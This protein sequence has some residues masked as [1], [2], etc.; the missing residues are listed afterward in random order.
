MSQPSQ[1]S[2]TFSGTDGLT[3]FQL[4]KISMATNPRFYGNLLWTHIKQRDDMR[5]VFDDM[6]TQHPNG[7]VSTKRCIK[8]MA[9]GDVLVCWN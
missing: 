1:V 5:F 3:T 2:T 9:G 8:V 7:L 6:V 4:Y